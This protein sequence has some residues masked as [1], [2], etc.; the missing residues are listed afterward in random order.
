MP[1]QQGNQF[2]Q[3]F[4]ASSLLNSNQPGPSPLTDTSAGSSVPSMAWLGPSSE[5]PPASVSSSHERSQSLSSVGSISPGSVT[6]FSSTGATAA[7][8]TSGSIVASQYS[9]PTTVPNAEGPSSSTQQHAVHHPGSAIIGS[10]VNTSTSLMTPTSSAQHTPAAVTP[11]VTTTPPSATTETGEG[12]GS[13]AV[14]AEVDPSFTS[15]AESTQGQATTFSSTL[16]EEDEEDVEEGAEE[17]AQVP[18][19]DGSG[20]LLTPTGDD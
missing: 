14:P 13:A 18:E 4:E 16:D 10:T 9:V 1:S 7:T 2:T 11:S 8:S 19:D 6:P 5:L 20:S 12:S 17:D 3:T 15:L